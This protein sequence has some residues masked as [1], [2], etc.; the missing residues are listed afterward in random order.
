V[1]TPNVAQAIADAKTGLK[2]YSST[3]KN[4]YLNKILKDLG[5]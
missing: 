3:T 4:T 1:I 5:G 2:S